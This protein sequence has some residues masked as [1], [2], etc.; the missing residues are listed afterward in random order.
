VKGDLIGTWRCDVC[1]FTGDRVSATAGAGL[2]DRYLTQG[3]PLAARHVLRERGAILR[4]GGLADRQTK[5][6][7]APRQ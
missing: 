7:H 3:R 6:N 1:P 2:I 5:K 4:K